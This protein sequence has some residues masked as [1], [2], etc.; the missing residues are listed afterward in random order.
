MNQLRFLAEPIVIDFFLSYF[1]IF[2]DE[3]YL[4]Y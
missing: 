3:E 2:L 4:I 1:L